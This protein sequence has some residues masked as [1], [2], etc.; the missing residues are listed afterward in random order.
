MGSSRKAKARHA[1]VHTKVRV[2]LRK[3]KKATPAPVI[4]PGTTDAT[5]WTED[6][7]L[8]RNYRALGL[9]LDVNPAHGRND[10]VVPPR[11]DDGDDGEEPKLAQ[12]AVTDEE[13]L[14]VALCLPL[15]A[16]Q[17]RPPKLLTEKQLVCGVAASVW[18]LVSR[19]CPASGA[20]AGGG[21]RRGC[22][23]DGTRPQA[24]RVPAHL[25]EAA[26]HGGRLQRAVER[27]Q[28]QAVQGARERL[29]CKAALFGVAPY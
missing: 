16:G 27:G 28:Q 24:E 17:V 19:D 2:G 1:S 9:A 8:R 15:A 22:G 11:E 25:V 4:L 23:G 10:P 6:A 13:S 29:T 18:C 5:R 21:A 14:R 20:R 3:A 26:R 7:T 12:T